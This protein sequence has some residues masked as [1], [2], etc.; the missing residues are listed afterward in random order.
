MKIVVGWPSPAKDLAAF[1][2]GRAEWEG[3]F[4]PLA[5]ANMSF[6]G[7]IYLRPAAPAGDDVRQ[8]DKGD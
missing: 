6:D 4:G 5:L 7:R 3:R 1:R 8:P 2:A